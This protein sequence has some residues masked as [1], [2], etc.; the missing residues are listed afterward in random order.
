VVERPANPDVI[1]AKSPV[2]FWAIITIGS[3]KYSQE[4]ELFGQLSTRI[5]DL[6][7]QSLKNRQAP[8]Q[9]VQALVILCAWPL[10]CDH[11]SQDTLHTLAGACMQLALHIGLH[12]A[13][14][15]QD[16]VRERI[17]FHA[18]EQAARARL[19]R[20]CLIVCHR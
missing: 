13:G 20:Y 10:P 5:L 18:V 9:T 6:V 17:Q 3:R 8:V 11:L 4:P 2:L 1:L 16:F 19:W 7:F 14:V 12:V 15:G